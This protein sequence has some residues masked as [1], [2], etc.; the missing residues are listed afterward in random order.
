MDKRNAYLQALQNLHREQ[1]SSIIDAELNKSEDE[2]DAALID[3]CLELIERLDAV[4]SNEKQPES[5]SVR[6]RV[7]TKRFMLAAAV[8]ALALTLC[9]TVLAV[10][11][12]IN[13]FSELIE[14][15]DTHIRV[16][17]DKSGEKA[18]EYKL[19]GSELAKELSEH[20]ISPVLLPEVLLTNEYK[21]TGVQHVEE[22]FFI[23][24]TVI[25]KK[26]SQKGHLN[27]SKYAFE[28]LVP[29]PNI[30]KDAKLVEQ[31]ELAGIIVFVLQQAEGETAIVYQ[32]GLTQY[33][34]QFNATLEDAIAFAK[35]I[36]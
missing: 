19:L 8:I 3:R 15:Y 35:T 31:I 23:D 29:A 34:I 20:G 14:Y 36:K 22:E 2:M 5:V 9:F 6:K 12:R 16:R 11:W 18:D 24:A 21:I 4:N 13:V 27:V 25:F 30:T 28:D 7:A 33:H 17:F 32:D 1:L 10:G 26:D